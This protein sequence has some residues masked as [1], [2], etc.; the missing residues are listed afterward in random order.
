MHELVWERVLQGGVFHE[1]LLSPILDV[2][3]QEANSLL[4]PTEL[5]L[6]HSASLSGLHECCKPQACMIV[7]QG[8][9]TLHLSIQVSNTLMSCSQWLRSHTP[10]F[11]GENLGSWT[12]ITEEKVNY[13][14]KQQAVNTDP[15]ESLSKYMSFEKANCWCCDHSLWVISYDVEWSLMHCCRQRECHNTR[16]AFQHILNIA[17]MFWS[18]DRIDLGLASGA[19]IRLSIFQTWNEACNL[20]YCGQWTSPKKRKIIIMII[21]II[22]YD[23]KWINDNIYV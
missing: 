10:I 16:A 13:A 7:L 12:V 18:I 2:Y 1:G 20:N 21:I 5:T 3:D 15:I 23:R 11:K 19:W 22:K 14:C 4:S 9:P 17:W 6:C 8:Q